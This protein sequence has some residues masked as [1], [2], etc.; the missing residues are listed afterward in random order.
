MTWDSI[1]APVLA[2]VIGG[3]FIAFGWI[4]NGWQNRR[5]AAHLRYERTRDVHRALYAEI[6]AHL[7]NLQAGQ[8]LQAHL[9][10]MLARMEAEP[11]FVPFVPRDEPDQIFDAIVGEIHVLPRVTID[12]IVAYYSQVKATAAFIDDMRGDAFARLSSARRAAMYQDY[13][14]MKQQADRFGEYA[15]R[16]IAIYAEKGQAAAEAFAASRKAGQ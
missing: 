10:M 13:I 5:E 2:A 15:K 4:V 8:G 12:P 14:L 11:D 7:A 3:A 16:V 9:D 6:G 1:P